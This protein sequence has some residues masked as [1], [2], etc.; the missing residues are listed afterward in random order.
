MVKMEPLVLLHTA[1]EYIC[2]DPI[3]VRVCEL[4]DASRIII[5]EEMDISLDDWYRP[6]SVVPINDM[7]SILP[8]SL[9]T[10][11]MPISTSETKMVMQVGV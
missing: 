7:A 6:V 4:D 8:S 5:M 2:V 9:T 1:Q 10:M 11:V 3:V